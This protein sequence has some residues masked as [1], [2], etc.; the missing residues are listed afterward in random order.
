MHRNSL[1]Q[2]AKWSLLC[3]IVKTTDNLWALALEHLGHLLYV[4]GLENRRMWFQHP[5]SVLVL[6]STTGQPQLGV[7][8]FAHGPWRARK[9]P[10]TTL[11]YFTSFRV[12]RVPLDCP[13]GLNH[14][15]SR[16]TLSN[17]VIW[18]TK[19]AKVGSTTACFKVKLLKF[20]LV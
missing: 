13:L 15:L 6:P 16:T 19:A 10:L 20:S 7:D 8:A 17:P 11:Q 14:R 18:T 5:R 2:E 3:C 12:E 9:S 4:R 1:H